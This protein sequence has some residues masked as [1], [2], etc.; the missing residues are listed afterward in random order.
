MEPRVKVKFPQ[1]MDAMKLR[2]FKPLELEVLE[3]YKQLMKP[4]ADALDKLQGERNCFLGFL[5]LTVQQVRKKLVMLN[6]KVI[7]CGSLIEGLIS[8]LD[9][10]FPHLFEYNSS[11]RIYAIV[12]ASHPQLKLRWVPQEKK[13]WTKKTFIEEAQ[14]LNLAEGSADADETSTSEYFF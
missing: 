8:N 9:Q 7:F 1:I 6:P 11:F 3:E 13:D 4:L 14:K 2:R 12:A 5:V 10:R